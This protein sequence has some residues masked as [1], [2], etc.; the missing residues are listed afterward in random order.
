MNVADNLDK[1]LDESPTD[2][3]SNVVSLTVGA[4]HNALSGFGKHFHAFVGALVG[5]IKWINIL[6]FFGGTTFIVI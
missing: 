2:E 3:A 4:I 1:K 6:N 5:T